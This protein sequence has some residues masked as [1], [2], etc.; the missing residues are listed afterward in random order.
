MCSGSDDAM[1]VFR[2][3]S[4]MEQMKTDILQHVEAPSNLVDKE[5]AHGIVWR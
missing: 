4:P 5:V 2:D 3:R 1:T